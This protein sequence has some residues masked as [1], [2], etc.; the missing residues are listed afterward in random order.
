M[1]KQRSSFWGFGKPSQKATETFK[2]AESGGMKDMNQSQAM[3]LGA[4]PSSITSLLRS[5]RREARDRITIYDK[6]SEMESNPFVSTALWLQTTAALGGHESTGQLVFIEQNGTE[7]DKQKLK[8]VDDIVDSLSDMLNSV[9][10]PM[11]YNGA[12]FGDAFARIYSEDKVGVTDIYTEELVRA[13]LVQPFEQ[14]SRTVGYALTTGNDQFERLNIAQMARMKMPRVTWVPQMGVFEKSLLDNLTNDDVSDHQLTPSS[15]GGSFLYAAEESYD[16]LNSS[17]AG[18]VG[19]RWLDSID[20]Q[21]ITI[22]MSD[23]TDDQQ[24]KYSKSALAMFQRSKQIAEDA[25][26][27]GRPF[28]ERIKHIIPVWSEKQVQNV[29]AMNGGQSGRNG[30]ISIEDVMLHARSLAGALGTD[31]SMIGFADQLSGGLGDGGFFRISTQSAERSRIAR[32]AL[33][34]CFN[35]I[36]DIHTMKKFGVVFSPSERPWKIT[37][38]ST[39]SALA[40]EQARTQLDSANGS[41]VILQAIQQLKDNGADENT[42]VAFMRDE[43]Q[44]DEDKAKI[45]AAMVKKPEGE[46]NEVGGGF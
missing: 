27:N 10:F 13:S 25:V 8:I 41:L 21:I 4:M 3:T 19:Q 32:I 44:I 9:A 17:M 36:I 38:Y 30:T 46:G 7:Q 26:K 29:S 23:M 15:V 42:A 20:E 45:Y 11:C 34:N 31:L 24:K 39:I 35:Q 5:G 43:L 22:N 33:T 28:L 1:K 16:H 18:I 12:A 40:A 14:G 2:A 6:W 37:F